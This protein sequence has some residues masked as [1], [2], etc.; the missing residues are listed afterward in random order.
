MSGVSYGAFLGMALTGTALILAFIAMLL[1]RR[2]QETYIARIFL[3]R[4]R[5]IRALKILLTGLILIT[6]NVTAR[7]FYCFNLMSHGIYLALSIICGSGL[8][9]SFILFFYENI[10]IMV[11]RRKE[12]RFG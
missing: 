4:A 7:I 3:E 10:K 9:I 2:S 6:V 12:S 11:G 5:I 1:G 8:A